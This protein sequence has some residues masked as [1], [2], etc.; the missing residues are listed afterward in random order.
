MRG[1]STLSLA[2]NGGE[3]EW[4]ARGLLKVS[5]GDALKILNDEYRR[6]GMAIPASSR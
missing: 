1:K 5:T 6:S 2:S 4:L 3:V